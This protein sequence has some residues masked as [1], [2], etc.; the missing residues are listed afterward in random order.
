MRWFTISDLNP[1]HTSAG[2]YQP[3]ILRKKIT[4]GTMP[5][6]NIVLLAVPVEAPTIV[7]SNNSTSERLHAAM[8]EIK[9]EEKVEEVGEL[10]ELGNWEIYGS[11]L[12]Y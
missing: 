9:E 11:N 5:P 8:T 2:S 1:I 12:V 10:G 3:L 4:V 7:P 6:T